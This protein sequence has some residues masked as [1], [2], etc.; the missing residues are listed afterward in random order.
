MTERKTTAIIGAGASGLATAR[1][2]RKLGHHDVVLLEAASC[3]GGK[4]ATMH[5]DGRTYELGAAFLT[6]AYTRVR[7]IM[8]EHN[9]PWT[10]RTSARFLDASG[11]G[12]SPRMWV[13]PRMSWRDVLRVPASALRV[14]LNE[15]RAQK[16]RFQR[17]DAAPESWYQSFAH[18]AR[19]HD[20]TPLLE[21]L[22]PWMTSFGYGFTDEVPAAYMLNY[23]SVLGPSFELHE[24]G[25]GGLWQRVAEA[26]DVRLDTRV[27]RITR[28]AARVTIETSRGDFEVDQVVITC[29]LDEASR[30]LDVS[31]EERPLFSQVRHM[32]YQVVA[33]DTLDMPKAA[34]LFCNDNATR[35]RV[36]KPVFC[37]HRYADT[38]VV[39]FY[40]YRG[41][42]G[43]DGAEREVISLVEGLGGR[44][45]K[46][47][48]R[49]D[50][51]YFPHVS[52]ESLASGFYRR[53][54]SLQGQNRTFYAGEI[55]SFACVESVVAY[56]EQL[57]TRI[58]GAE[59]IRPTD[60]PWS[61]VANDASDHQARK[62]A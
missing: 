46:I 31:D 23:M 5:H 36:G 28:G 54:E 34:Y 30:L 6:P 55:M 43:L 4:C 7:E 25:Y 29:P 33:A 26:H 15:V 58:L 44:V 51:R 62:I 53:L 18:W 60:L 27:R 20:A 47:L 48:A 52:S 8:A 42:D 61:N 40:S 45:R 38:G 56:G 35:A 21:A 12:L 14:Y 17:L 19:Q 41:P 9:V 16:A 24:T 59:N 39:T 57:A 1:A 10:L 11:T 37:Y 13:P 3:V 49:R 50:Y 32:D 2:L 22:R